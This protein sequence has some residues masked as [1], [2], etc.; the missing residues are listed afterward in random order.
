[1][2]V[3]EMERR[4][5]SFLKDALAKVAAGKELSDSDP[6]I[7][8]IISMVQYFPEL[9]YV[10]DNYADKEE[11][12]RGIRQQLDTRGAAFL[13]ELLALYKSPVGK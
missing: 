5:E 3:L 11:V 1:M 10:C 13:D 6:A 8:V 9:N 7:D 4:N 12:K 2:N